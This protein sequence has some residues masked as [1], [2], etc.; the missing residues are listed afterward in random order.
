MSEGSSDGL[1]IHYLELVR[2]KGSEPKV[3]I[4]KLY[5]YAK[6]NN[7]YGTDVDKDEKE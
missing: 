5:L 3:G 1:N 4:Y 2:N 6:Y 7:N